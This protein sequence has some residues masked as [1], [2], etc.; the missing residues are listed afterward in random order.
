MDENIKLNYREI[1]D[2]ID[3][4]IGIRDIMLQ[5]GVGLIDDKNGANGKALCPFHPERTP[6][7]HANYEMN[8]FHC[9]GCHAGGNIIEFVKLKLNTTDW[10]EAV[11]AIC[12]LYN[13]DVKWTPGTDEKNLLRKMH[14]SLSRFRDVKRTKDF[15]DRFVYNINRKIYECSRLKGLQSY[16]SKELFDFYTLIDN[17]INSE[18]YDMEI[19]VS[20][21]RMLD[22]KLNK[23]RENKK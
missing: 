9:F 16:E 22:S 12:N 8:S 11:V 18:N 21:N 5:F 17:E 7:F 2:I 13:I 3:S 20:F 4:E 6:S 14:S 1:K 19:M 15:Y 10:F 23:L